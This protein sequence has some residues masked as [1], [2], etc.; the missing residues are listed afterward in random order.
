MLEGA[1]LIGAGAATI[2][3]AGAAVGIGNF[4][5]SLIQSVA[6]NTSLRVIFP[7]DA[8]EVM[9]EFAPIS[10]YLVMSLLVSVIL[11]I[12][13]IR[14]YKI[15][16]IVFSFYFWVIFFFLHYPKIV[17]LIYHFSNRCFFFI[18]AGGFETSSLPVG[19]ED[20]LGG[21]LE[22]S[23][24]D[25][26]S[27]S[28]TT[29]VGPSNRILP[30]SSQILQ[31]QVENLL[32]KNH[33]SLLCIEHELKNLCLD[34][35]IRNNFPGLDFDSLN[36]RQLVKPMLSG[37]PFFIQSQD[38]LDH[39]TD[40]FESGKKEDIAEVRGQVIDFFRNKYPDFYKAR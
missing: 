9:S 29:G 28:N 37:Y 2:A 21:V 10:I 36:Y 15:P 18:A 5:S 38:M 34:N 23:R 14:F 31:L 24:M 16:K 11:I 7:C 8:A 30:S 33:N 3:L 6:R 27:H 22:P 35:K 20:D 17:G 25:G 26:P 39:V 1:K 19:Q 40:V 13:G 12:V 32:N 4:F